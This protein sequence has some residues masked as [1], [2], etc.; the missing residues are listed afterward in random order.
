MTTHTFLKHPFKNNISSTPANEA[1]CKGGKQED[2]YI[3]HQDTES[4]IT[5]SLRLKVCFR[6]LYSRKN[7]RCRGGVMNDFAIPS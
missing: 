6:L 5:S 7:E 3:H 2:A 1:I 4:F